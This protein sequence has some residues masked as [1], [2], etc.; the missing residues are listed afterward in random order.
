MEGDFQFFSFNKRLDWA[1]GMSYN[2]EI[3]DNGMTLIFE[4]KYALHRTLRLSDNSVIGDVANFA[5][6]S[7]SRIVI[8]NERSD[9]I[10]YDMEND[11]PEA[12]FVSGHGQFT[13]R[14]HITVSG[15]LLFVA[16]A[17]VTHKV[18]A[19]SLANGQA[20]WQIN[21]VDGAK[22]EPLALAC[23]RSQS[24]YVLCLLESGAT[25]LNGTA[26]PD[27][28]GRLAIVKI[29]R[30]GAFMHVYTDKF[31]EIEWARQARIRQQFRHFYLACSEDGSLYVMDSKR[32]LIVRFLP[33]GVR[34]SAYS[35]IGE[36]MP[37][38]IATDSQ[39]RLIVG[40]SRVEGGGENRRFMLIYDR[41]GHF[42]EA[43]SG[44]RPRV[45]RLL[46]G[47]ADRI[48]VQSGNDEIIIYE[49]KPRTVPNAENGMLEGVYFTAAIDSTATETVWHKL[50]LESVIPEQTQLRISYFASDSRELMIE[51]E[52]RNV[53]EWLLSSRMSAAQ[54][55]AALAHLWSPAIVN[56]RD[57]LFFGAKGRYL[58][59]KIEW[60]G[61]EYASPLLQR[62]RIYFPRFSYLS[63][64]PAIYQEQGGGGDFLERFLAL[65]GT[66]YEQLEEKIAGISH[67]FDVD[68]ASGPFLRWLASWVGLA[69]EERWDD[70]QV[71]K[72]L[73][74]SPE[75]FRAWGTRR[76]IEEMIEICIGEKPYIVEHFQVKSFADDSRL[77]ELFYRLYGDNPYSFCIIVKSEHVEDERKR[78]MIE[79]IVLEQKPAHTEAKIVVLQPW[80]FMDMHTYLG[81]NTY[82]SEPSLLRL[83]NES[84]MPHH[85]V[86]ID[87][88][89]DNRVGV[90][91]RLELD[92][93]LE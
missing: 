36:G 54:K 44:T 84:S 79:R 93:G 91:T 66:F 39:G 85:T 49:L 89:R 74:R 15:D 50:Q 76:G 86:I 87:I 20:I 34:G 19:Y 78:L 6:S 32:R 51:G 71:R 11:H 10:L 2:L 81:M 53:D 18:S 82:L 14:A 31:L 42:K 16:D 26:S 48:Y 69:F 1:K 55:N 64:L 67:Y 9:L 61:N 46:C 33:D 24:A 38:G 73:Q 41:A 58:W 60:I 68:A 40:W 22:I 57:A 75:L 28:K 90:H 4:N 3:T 72:L 21:E 27:P 37:R 63:Y 43:V 17:N 83:D 13:N 80:M 59:L 23:D 52:Y 77:R 45:E 7:G 8:L 5:M 47:P 30:N 25:S 88:D 56:P 12:L 70:E 92:S 62:M 29:G 65:F 35:V